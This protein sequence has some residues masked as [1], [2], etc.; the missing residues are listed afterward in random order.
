MGS[1]RPDRGS[2]IAEREAARR[3]DRTR[4][5]HGLGL[6]PA[7]PAGQGRS[8]GLLEPRSAETIRAAGQQRGM[9]AGDPLGLAGAA[10][11]DTVPF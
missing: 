8:R 6:H 10:S 2:G 3:P 9:V 5:L 4:G 11:T 1:R 7:A